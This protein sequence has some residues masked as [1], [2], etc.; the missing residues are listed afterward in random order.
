MFSATFEPFFQLIIYSALSA[1]AV[2]FLGHWA[3]S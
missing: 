2:N 3:R 1:F